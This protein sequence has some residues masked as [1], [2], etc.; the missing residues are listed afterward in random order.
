MTAQAVKVSQATVEAA[1][2]RFRAQR[3]VVLGDVMVDRYLWGNVRRISPE[4]PVP[5]V[6]VNR[7]TMRLGGAANVAANVRSLGGTPVLIGVIGWRMRRKDSRTVLHRFSPR[8]QLHPRWRPCRPS[9]VI[10][11]RVTSATSPS[12]SSTAFPV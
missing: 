7:E 4:A 2:E 9:I 3:I 5:I 6:E 12:Y 1:L 8:R 11:S 10:A